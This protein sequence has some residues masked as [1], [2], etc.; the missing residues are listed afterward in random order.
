MRVLLINPNSDT[1]ASKKIAASANSLALADRTLDCICTCGTPEFIETYED[2]ATSAQGMA[3][4]VRRNQDLYDAFVVACGYD[5]NLDMLKE[6]SE[7][8]ITGI[9][10]ASIKI[11]SMLGHKFTVLCTDA[12]SIP[13]KEDLI[14]KYG[15]TQVLASVRSVY[16][17][18]CDLTEEE[19]AY[20][21][22]AVR[23]VEEDGAET[24][25]LS[26]ACASGLDIVLSK[27]LGIPVLD[28]VKCGLIV[29]YGLAKYGISIS[30]R[31]KYNPIAD[32][33]IPR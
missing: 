7:K 30:K 14:Q 21:N 12:H 2:M 25:I 6:I 20:F 4:I 5:P 8:P 31:R 27:R 16:S 11:A 1:A 33:D 29:A 13:I 23:A 19:D 10:E 32:C 22:A 18:S 26:C 9:C 24:I 28:G 3:D 15:M 17:K